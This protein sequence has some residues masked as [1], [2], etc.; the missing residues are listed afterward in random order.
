MLLF[1]IISLHRYGLKKAVDEPFSKAT[2]DKFRSWK[3]GKRLFFWFIVPG[4]FRSSTGNGHSDM[5]FM[6]E[7]HSDKGQRSSEDS[8]RET[9]LLTSF[10]NS[11]PSEEELAEQEECFFAEY[12]SDK[13][14]SRVIFLVV[15]VLLFVAFIVSFGAGSGQTYCGSVRRRCCRDRGPL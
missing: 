12:E 8:N 11:A 9:S 10:L 4:S 13:R 7:K 14:R 15:I 2:P 6:N 3:L 1:I 5:G